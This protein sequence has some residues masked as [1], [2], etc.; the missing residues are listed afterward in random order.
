MSVRTLWTTP[1]GG[2]GTGKLSKFGTGRMADGRFGYL[3]IPIFLFICMILSLL[4]YHRNS[5]S[6]RS[7]FNFS[8]I[9]VVYPN[10][11][12]SIYAKSMT[13]PGS[14]PSYRSNAGKQS[15][16]KV[17]VLFSDENVISPQM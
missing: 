6:Q 17:S 12:Y 7:F 14:Q 5:K 4:P 9:F 16:Q 3:T 2:V 1:Y 8:T 13:Y 15:S 11:S 10:K